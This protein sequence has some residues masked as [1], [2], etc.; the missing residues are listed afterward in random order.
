MRYFGEMSVEETAAALHLSPDSIITH[1]DRNDL[2]HFSRSGEGRLLCT[3][4]T[5]TRTAVMIHNF[6]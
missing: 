1:F 5:A 6:R 2:I 4:A 3:R